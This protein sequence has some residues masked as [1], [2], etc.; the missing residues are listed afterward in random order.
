MVKLKKSQIPEFWSDSRNKHQQIIVLE[1]DRSA[2][3]SG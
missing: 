2:P 1:K 3:E